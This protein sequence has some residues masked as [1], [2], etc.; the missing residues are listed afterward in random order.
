MQPRGFDDVGA[1]ETE[2]DECQKTEQ[3]P[4]ALTGVE[5]NWVSAAVWSTIWCTCPPESSH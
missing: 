5:V 2:P 4:A 1:P 3:V